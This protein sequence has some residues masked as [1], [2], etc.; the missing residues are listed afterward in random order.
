MNFFGTHTTVTN[1]LGATCLLTLLGWWLLSGRAPSRK[2]PAQLHPETPRFSAEQVLD[3]D[4][5]GRK[6]SPEVEAIH[7]QEGFATDRLYSVP[8]AGVHPRMLFGPD[9]LPR[10]RLQFEV[11]PTASSALAQ[12]RQHVDELLND[13]QS[14]GHEVWRA[15]VAGDLAGFER[16]WADARNP[17]G[18]G[19]SPGHGSHPF[20]T[21]LSY[22]AFL[23]LLDADQAR[24]QA[25][26]AAI[27]AYAQVL[28][29]RIEEAARLPGAEH[30]WLAIRA[31]MG[32]AAE[33]GFMYDFAQPFMT[34]EQTTTVRE[35]IALAT[36]GRYGLGMDLPP[37][38]VNWNFIGMGLYFPLLALSIEGEPGY[39]ARIY[40]RG[41]EVAQ[42]YILHGN[43]GNGVGREAVGYHTA[44]MS[45]AAMFMLAMANRGR[46]LFTLERWRNMFEQWL[47]YAMQPYGKEWQSSGDLGTFPPNADLVGIARYFYP[48]NERIR[49]IAANRELSK[50]VY[51]ALDGPWLQL[52][53]PADLTENPTPAPK[54]ADFELPVTLFDEQRGLLFTRTGWDTED[55]AL[56]VTCRSDTTYHSHDHPDRGAFYLTALG[57]SWAVSSGRM[58]EPKYL[59]T[60]TVDG[61]GQGYFPP[62]G[63]WVDLQDG[64]EATFAVMD[65]GYCYDWQW[66][67]TCWAMTD[68]QLKKEPWLESAR[69]TR[70]LLLSRFPRESWERDPLPSVRAYYEDYLAGNPRMWSAESSWVLRA[71]HYPVARAFR[72]IGLV[73]G[74]HPYVL[75]MDDMQKD[76]L[77]HLYQW[78]M[79]LPMRVEA[80]A[81][82]GNDVIL[83]ALTDRRDPAYSVAWPN[84]VGGRPLPA[85]GQPLLLVRVIQA[86]QPALPTLQDNIAVETIEFRKHDDTHQ[87]PGRTQGLGKRLVVPSRSVAPDFKILMVPFRHGEPLPETTLSA[88]GRRLVVEWPHQADHYTLRHNEDGRTT[89]ERERVK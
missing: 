44:G 87:F 54:A 72:T 82:D 26:A 40:Q 11:S 53:C 65:V 64:P 57:Q 15:L 66:S 62:P 16:L 81:I 45:H 69:A 51:T 78:R 41:G 60:I 12:L 27:T 29:P 37:H 2:A 80:Y 33:V 68:E 59:N 10:L 56:W 4:M 71:P 43:S 58:T 42:N 25:V 86:N 20:T 75:I 38:W 9:D 28:R 52:L 83:G 24:G 22:Q 8:P 67:P 76:D 85:K 70:D 14:W 46:N 18:G 36:R 47:I 35:S 49:F 32:D 63:K 6:A 30:Y 7:A 84:N 34:P 5:P 48:E 21:A 23:A 79:R 17:K 73:R 1:L 89:F 50:K 39:D 55:V 19:G 88:D 31:V 3:N 74:K 61:R 77:E 13:P